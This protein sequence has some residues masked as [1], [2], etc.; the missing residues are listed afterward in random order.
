[1]PIRRRPGGPVCSRACVGSRQTPDPPSGTRSPS[2]RTRG[3]SCGD[4]A[5]RTPC[6]LDGWLVRDGMLPSTRR[7]RWSAADAGAQVFGARGRPRPQR[8]ACNVT[9]GPARPAGQPGHPAGV[10]IGIA[11]GASKPAVHPGPLGPARD[12]SPAGCAI[13]RGFAPPR[14]ARYCVWSGA[15]RHAGRFSSP[16]HDGSS[17]ILRNRHDHGGCGGDDSP[18]DLWQ[19]RPT[20]ERTHGMSRQIG[21]S[22]ARL[23]VSRPG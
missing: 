21:G 5:C 13:S 18:V 22:T 6:R 4:S 9:G 7:R 14:E 8:A 20:A 3:S 19:N 15:S 16:D 10:P 1:M 12:T 2:L 23:A 17:G 11:P